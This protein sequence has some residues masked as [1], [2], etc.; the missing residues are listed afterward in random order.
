[1]NLAHTMRPTT[2]EEFVGQDHLVGKNGLIRKMIEKQ[3]LFSII[4]WGP[5]GTG[6]T[7][8]ASL[9]AHAFDADFHILSGATSGKDDLLRI[10][11]EAKEMVMF[12]KKTI[13][14]IDE[15]HRW[16]KAQQDV[17]LPYVESGLIT[18][19]GATT[20]KPSFEVIS[21]LLSRSRVFVMKSLSMEDLEKILEKGLTDKEKGMGEKENK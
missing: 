14:F 7:T 8:L 21:P 11:K 10:V 18:L 3:N 6:K 1:M 15:I 20:E 13:V 2:L 17:L 5:P 19:I 16:N 9:I 12:Q 4:F